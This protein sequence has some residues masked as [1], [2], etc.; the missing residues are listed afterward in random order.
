MWA[1]AEQGRLK[2]MLDPD[3]VW[4]YIHP[5]DV[6]AYVARAT[7]VSGIEGRIVEVGMDAPGHSFRQLAEALG[8]VLAKPITVTA[9]PGWPLRLVLGLAS[10]FSGRAADM[11]AMLRF[12]E[13]GQYVHTSP[14][15]QKQ[16]FGDPPTAEASMRRVA[17]SRGWLK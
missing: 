1:G 7:D 13:S 11:R 16:F 2:S 17:S 10:V 8:K 15:L 14:E 5:D 4:S 9:R 3:Q 6:A 12:F